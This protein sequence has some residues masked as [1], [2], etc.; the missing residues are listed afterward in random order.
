LAAPVAATG[1]HASKLN[2]PRTVLAIEKTKESSFLVRLDARSL[3]P[4]S[5]RLSLGGFASAWALSPNGRRLALSFNGDHVIRIVDPH[6]LKHVG[7]IRGSRDISALAWPAPRRLVWLG[8]DRVGVG[9]PTTRR[10]LTTAYLDGAVIVAFRRVGSSLVLLAPPSGEIGSARL[11]VFG[12]D[13]RLRTLTLTGIRAGTTFEPVSMQGEMRQPGLAFTSDA[14]TF[15][16]G[17][18]DEPVAEVDLRTMVATYYRPEPRRSLLAKLHDWLE[19]RAEAKMQLPGSSRSALSLGKSRLAVWGSDS[20]RS[21]PEKVETTPTGLSIINTQ[22]WTIEPVDAQA[23]HVALAAGTLLTTAEG[24]GLTGYSTDGQRRYRV[25]D[26][27][28]VWVAATFGSRVYVLPRRGRMRVVDA[29]TGRVVGT[30][31]AVPWILHRD[32]SWQ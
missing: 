1:D 8:A 11:A 5:R 4:V 17:A 30:R 32:F 20:V 18:G 10:Q 7:S 29:A 22:D 14:R 25:F 28:S 24:A 12:G 23:E 27:E 6:R 2:L 13:G 9:D 15:V 3:K 16:I 19:P 21:G 31:R 26:G